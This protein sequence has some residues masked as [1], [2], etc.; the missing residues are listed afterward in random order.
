MW[1][2]FIGSGK[3]WYGFAFALAFLASPGTW[4]GIAA[5]GVGGAPDQ[6]L[7]DG[8]TEFHGGLHTDPAFTGAGWLVGSPT[9]RMIIA[10]D[11]TAPNWIKVL[12]LPPTALVPFSTQLG[13]IEFLH[14]GPG[15]AWTD[16][17]ERITTPGWEWDLGAVLTAEDGQIVPGVR[18]DTNLD[19][20]FETLDFFFNPLDPGID[21]TIEKLIHCG[22]PNGCTGEPVIGHGFGILVREFPTVVPAPGTLLL[23]AGGLAGLAASRRRR[24]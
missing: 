6:P 23:L 16:W 24:G 18:S 3:G 2:D 12:Q 11:P 1:K 15:P 10:A 22:A 8:R 5:P 4:A 14:V 7:V 21:V 13:M 17:H 19:G 9:G 20:L